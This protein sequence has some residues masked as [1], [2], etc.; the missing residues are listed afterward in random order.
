MAP[1]VKHVY[2]V[3]SSTILQIFRQYSA[4]YL[5]EKLYEFD[6]TLPHSFAGS[7]ILQTVKFE[8]SNYQ[9]I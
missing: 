9:R 7:K 4:T 3:D 2:A 6:Q 1:N 5:N 8:L